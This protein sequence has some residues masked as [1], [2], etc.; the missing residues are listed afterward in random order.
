MRSLF[1][2]F[3]ILLIAASGGLSQLGAA[4]PESKPTELTLTPSEGTLHGPGARQQ[5]LAIGKV[6]G[7][8]VDL[9][10]R[11]KWQTT[12]PQLVTINDEGV[13]IA[14]GDGQARITATLGG[15]TAALTL[16]ITG[17]TEE[18]RP[19]FERDVLPLLSRAGC[20]A[21]SCHGKARGQNGFQLSII[22]SDPAFDF[23]SI[24]LEARGRRVFPAAPSQSL[25]LLKGTAQLSHGGGRRLE[26]DGEALATIQRWIET[27]MP[28]TPADAPRL[29]QI[30]VF[31]ADRLMAPGADQQLVVTAHFSDGTTHDV[32]HL[33]AFQSNES[34]IVEVNAQ[35]QIKAGPIPGEAA[36]TARFRDQ[37]ATSEVTIPLPGQ[38]PD[39][40]YAEL[41]RASFIDEHVWTKLK[42][43]GIVPSPPAND[44]TYLR[45]VSLDIIG[46]PPTPDEIRS[47]LA[48]PSPEKRAM[49]V[50][51]LLQR[52]EYADVWANKWLDLLRPNPYRVGIKA[53]F[54]LDNWI[55][56]AFRQNLPYDQFVRRI[57]T[58]QGSTFR[59]GAV[60]VFRDRREPDEIA[61][62]VSQLFLGIRLDCAKCHHHPFE[63]WGQEDFYGFAAYFARIGRK[64]VGLSPPISGSEEI[65]FTAKA[66]TVKHPISGEVLP[67][68]PLFGSAP[69]T[70]DPDTD[71]RE[72]LADWM[73]GPENRYF[74]EV[75]V[76][77]VW[78][79]LM[80]RGIVEPV[81][82][83][84]ATNPASNPPLLKALADDFRE[85]KFDLKHLIRTI[86]T[87]TV[88][89]LSSEPNERNSADT[90]NYS[91]HYR[92]RLRAE[93]LLD[94][95]ADITEV[96]NSFQAMPPKSRAVAIWTH[97]TPSIF[98]DTFGRPD[99]NQDPPCE[100]TPD[101]SVT[102]ALH[103]MNSPDLHRM[104]TSDQ[105]RAARLASDKDKKSPREIVEE[106][107]LLVYNRLPTDEERAIGQGVFDEPKTTPRQA[108]ED[109]LWALINSAEFVFKD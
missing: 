53:V 24:V 37:F 38:V 21:G 23:A 22:A 41:P 3:A 27:G 68:K 2:I 60:T 12:T 94:A 82:D 44:A 18:F 4:E 54:N 65:M 40:V 59:N 15:Q 58:A 56:D 62:M 87:S 91:R 107:Y 104:I 49:V 69:A 63:A 70:T 19:T 108:T 74:A 102:Q 101:T 13:A 43:L 78:A 26:P 81:D 88:Y 55:R 67:P 71:P 28:R 33:A 103:L 105:G 1:N 14:K 109:L 106:L 61:P 98:L 48:D 57:V 20:N 39:R 100:R 50:D 92:Q 73:T 52:P 35:G 45:R 25:I 32:T 97:R 29:E 42:R 36:I 85:H 93:V 9:T 79:D 11:V 10:R 84:R 30:T 46:R 31:P 75:I 80:G 6:D 86:V 66:G 64:G 5:L 95:I 96:E 17:M 72:A 77:R 83:L 8:P 7:L 51:R 89:G 99:P 34:G 47:F 90:R 76:N 16:R